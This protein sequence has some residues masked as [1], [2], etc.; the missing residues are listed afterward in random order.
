MHALGVSMNIQRSV[1]RDQQ[2]EAGQV[3]KRI[4]IMQTDAVHEFVGVIA[5]FGSSATLNRS[6]SHPK[7][8]QT[9]IPTHDL[10][11]MTVYFMSIRRLR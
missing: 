2:Q 9:R 7:F 8:E 3:Y 5:K 1:S 10:Q 11:M 6:T 4:K